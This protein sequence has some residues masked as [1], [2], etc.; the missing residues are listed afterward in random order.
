MKFNCAQCGK[1]TDRAP[2]HV[3]R[4]RRLGNNLYCGRACSAIGRQTDT[5]TDAEKRAAKSAYDAEYR[6]KNI[7][8]IKAKKATYYAENHDREKE[9]EYRKRT[10]ARH[11]EYCRR[12]E[13]REYKREYD[14]E[15]R[16]KQDYGE[17]WECFLL[18]MSIRDEA[19]RQAGGD[20]ELRLMKG[21]MNKA[22]KRRR[23]YERLDREEP[24]DFALGDLER[25]E[26][27]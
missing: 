21:T 8:E 9:R 14:K 26:R 10:M 18:A 2:G 5:R 25:G 6:A 4:A 23:D 3:N 22:I 24:E 19:V 12:P 7:T 11:V 16:A 15:Y 27:R 17:F 13:Y 20:Y 1:E